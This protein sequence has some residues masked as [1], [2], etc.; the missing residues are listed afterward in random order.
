MIRGRARFLIA[1]LV[2]TLA[3]ALAAPLSID[4]AGPANATATEV[5]AVFALQQPAGGQVAQPGQRSGDGFEP[6]SNLPPVP[7]EQLPAAP[8]V[9]LA[10]AFVWVMV[11]GYVWSLWRR[12]STVERELRSV[13][14]RVDEAGRR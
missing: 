6:V 14:Q 7:Q 12:L 4:A 5:G 10:Y 3:T 2:A 9:M 1:A 11:L 13:A 8:L